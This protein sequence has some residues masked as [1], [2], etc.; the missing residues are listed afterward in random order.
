[1]RERDPR[2]T[3][4]NQSVSENRLQLQRERPQ[5][6]QD[7]GQR[8]QRKRRSKPEE[9]EVNEVVEEEEETEV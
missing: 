9:E 4:L 2:A 3:G 6:H 5:Q 7:A 8:S 1:M